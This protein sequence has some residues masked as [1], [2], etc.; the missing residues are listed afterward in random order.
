MRTVGSRI[1]SLL[2]TLFLWLIRRADR[3]YQAQQAREA[4]RTLDAKE[5]DAN[6][7]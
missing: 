7:P 4:Q 2:F 1:R 6:L 5:S 3:R